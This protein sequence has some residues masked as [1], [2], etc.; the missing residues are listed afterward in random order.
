MAGDRGGMTE[1]TVWPAEITTRPLM[2]P[3]VPLLWRT[4]TSIQIGD[5]VIVDDVSGDAIRWLAGLD[6]SRTCIDASAHK[7]VDAADQRVL[8]HAAYQA[9]ALTDS[10][11]APDCWRWVSLDERARVQQDWAAAAS[12]FLPLD[13]VRGEAVTPEGVIDARWRTHISVNG[14]SRLA[15][16][17]RE[18]VNASG[19]HLAEPTDTPDATILC[20]PG[21]SRVIPMSMPSLPHI[22]VGTHGSQ[23]VVG[24][25][26]VPGRTSCL[27][28]AQLHH[29]D[30]DPTWPLVA[31]Q[32]QQ[33]TEGAGAPAQDH[34][35]LSHCATYALILLRAWIDQ[36]EATERWGNLAIE[37]DLG[38]HNP[39]L[40]PHVVSRPTHPSCG[41]TW[42]R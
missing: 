10:S 15:D 23:S 41:C 3:E 21:H 4:P 27:R 38:S 18:A 11:L 8:A 30:A 14:T 12:A 29:R 32:W 33:H 36:P 13:A 24:P 31:V 2:R 39:S 9:G 26:V 40:A 28:C 16:A 35:L 1:P 42:D 17:V 6:G 20:S 37:T 7:A 34:L 25:M 22:H 19:M 5:H